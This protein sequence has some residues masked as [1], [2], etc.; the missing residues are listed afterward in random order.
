MARTVIDID[1]DLLRRA[2]ELLGASTKRD[3][4]NGALRELVSR[5]A[6]LAELDRLAKGE[7][8]DL[9]DPAVMAQAWR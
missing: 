1:E 9:G 7:L 3:T 6:R 5:R 4:V 8:P 2:A